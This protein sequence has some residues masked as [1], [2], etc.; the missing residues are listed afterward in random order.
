M[1]DNTN[2]ISPENYKSSKYQNLGS[3]LLVSKQLQDLVSCS[4]LV[5]IKNN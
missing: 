1:Q 4:F 5:V 3:N 2:F